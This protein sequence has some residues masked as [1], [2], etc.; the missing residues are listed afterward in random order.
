MVIFSRNGARG[1]AWTG[2]NPAAHQHLGP[3]QPPQVLNR[4]MDRHRDQQD[5][6]ENNPEIE[7]YGLHFFFNKVT[8]VE[9]RKDSAFNTWTF[10]GKRKINLDLIFIPIQN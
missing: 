6:K 2:A 3:D 4:W 8:K 1:R 9:Q 7:K 10:T 5:R